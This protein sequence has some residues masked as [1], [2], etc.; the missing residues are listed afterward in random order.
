MPLF[1]KD[2]KTSPWPG[3][4]LHNGTEMSR[5]AYHANMV[6]RKELISSIY[7]Q[8]IQFQTDNK[9]I[10]YECKQG[11][12]MNNFSKLKTSKSF[13]TPFR[14]SLHSVKEMRFIELRCFKLIQNATLDFQT[15]NK[16]C[17]QNCWQRTRSEKPSPK[18][19]KGDCS[20]AIYHSSTTFVL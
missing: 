3:G 13:H 9:L 5:E 10:L 7:L 16:L 18:K 12:C 15:K 2:G 17:P 19:T 4:Y 14:D 1:F 20:F 11:Y 8:G 6:Q